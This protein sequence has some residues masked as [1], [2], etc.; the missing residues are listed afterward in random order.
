MSI[1]FLR[2]DSATGDTPEPRTMELDESGVQNFLKSEQDGPAAYLFE[3]GDL[4]VLIALLP[5]TLPFT[6]LKTQHKNVT[7]NQTIPLRQAFARAHTESAA[8]RSIYATWRRLFNGVARLFEG[9]T[10]L[11][12]RIFFIGVPK[13]LW[14]ETIRALEDR[15]VHPEI[16]ALRR[17]FI[18]KSVHAE[19]VRRR[20]GVYAP[21]EAPVLI[22]GPSGTGKEVVAR[23]LHA[24][25]R[26]TGPF[27][28]VNTAAVAESLFEDELFGR[29]RGAFTGATTSRVGAIL[30]AQN[31]TLFFDEIGDLPLRLQAKLLR[32]LQERE[33]MRLGDEKYLEFNARIVAATNRDLVQM[34]ARGEFR[35]DLYYRLRGF[36]IFTPPLSGAD[37]EAHVRHGWSKVA[38]GVGMPARILR[39]LCARH[40]SGNV[41]ELQVFLDVLKAE[42]GDCE[43]T[44]ERLEKLLYE[45]DTGR[46][47]LVS[48]NT[49]SNPGKRLRRLT[50]DFKELHDDYA[51]A[52]RAVEG[53]LVEWTAARSPRYEIETRTRSPGE[54]ANSLQLDRAD[55]RLAEIP[56]LCRVRVVVESTDAVR[57]LARQLGCMLETEP[58]GATP[59]VRAGSP[60]APADFGVVEKPD[61][62]QDL[63]FGP[64]RCRVRVGDTPLA[65]LGSDFSLLS[66]AARDVWVDV[67]FRTVFVDQWETVRDDR[68]VSPEDQQR[69]RQSLLELQV[70]A[71]R[72][73]ATCREPAAREIYRSAADMRRELEMVERSLACVPGDTNLSVRA[74][75]LAGLLGDLDR[76]MRLVKPFSD[77][78]RAAVLREIGIKICARHA[79][80]SRA[81]RDGLK[82][83][84]IAANLELPDD[85]PSDDG[86]SH[87]CVMSE[88][89]QSDVP[90]L[91][92]AMSELRRMH[93]PRRRHHDA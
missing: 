17:L 3:N 29:V 35:A 6:D 32:V 62:L 8:I 13:D 55:C 39:A 74:A 26:R 59:S 28:A 40:W 45:Q 42:S 5:A 76:V 73:R 61:V 64:T 21:H 41:R 30:L 44:P 68:R 71:D 47:A 24:F 19:E 36:Q 23:L 4:E 12:P 22:T 72:I 85:D 70:Q 91:G 9:S 67:E 75:T 2:M 51:A 18:G 14:A 83:Q 90:M 80:S 66:E 56:D 84:K 53:L 88:I 7:T 77:E 27:H 20:I 52:G 37:V 33:V 58:R 11:E 10:I 38:K 65:T 34:V 48:T 16:V 81:Y 57:D 31:G 82:L 46:P 25:S 87:Y 43:P 54:L 86:R 69:F 63:H 60:D 79:R 89:N 50:S 1:V 92:K 15:C 93:V 78:D 49:E